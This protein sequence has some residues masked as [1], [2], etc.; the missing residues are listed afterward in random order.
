MLGWILSYGKKFIH[1]VFYGI[2]LDG[3]WG[4]SDK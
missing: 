3:R 2:V 1:S 4:I